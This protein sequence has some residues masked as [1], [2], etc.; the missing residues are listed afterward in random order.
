MKTI[1]I[2]IGFFLSALNILIAQDIVIKDL[3]CKQSFELIQEHSGD[4]DFVIIDLR[5]ENM[6]QEEH[7]V[8]SIFCDVFS[9]E[10][11]GWV[12]GLNK[13]KIYLLYCNAGKRSKVALEKMKEEGFNNLYH[14]Y[15]GIRVWKSQGYSTSKIS[16]DVTLV[17]NAINDV[18]GW[19][20]NK[21]FDLFFNTISEDS[22]F[23]SVTPYKKIKFGAK[24]VRNDTAFWA[25][26]DFKAISHELLDL[27]INFSSDRNVAW[28]YCMLN[29][30]NTW[31]GEPANWENVRWTGVLE[32]RNGNWRV[33]QQHFSWPKEK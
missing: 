5:P 16:S 29:D 11:D 15:E 27:R 3:T 20:V 33:V 2:T 28:F 13:D 12:N 4:T 14:L 32:K 8:N 31:K 17:Q 18:F 9:A 24:A 30:I 25:S 23:I 7:I 6:Y 21:D 1:I 19:A 10:F 26:P 22:N